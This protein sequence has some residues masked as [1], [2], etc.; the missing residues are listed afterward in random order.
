MN[1]M[2]LTLREISQK[3]VNNARKL[4]RRGVLKDGKD[5]WTY[6]QMAWFEL[7]HARWIDPTNADAHYHEGLI[8]KEIGLLSEAAE[9]FQDAIELLQRAHKHLPADNAQ[10]PN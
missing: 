10:V 4:I 3:K 9:R 5:G 8:L 1:P 7:S 2:T 6:Y